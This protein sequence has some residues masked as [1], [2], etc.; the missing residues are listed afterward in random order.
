VTERRRRGLRSSAAAL[1][2]NERQGLIREELAFIGTCDVCGQVR[3]KGVPAAELADRP[4]RGVGWTPTNVMINAFGIIGQTPFGALGDVM[5]V[6]DHSAEI[7]VDYEDGGPIEHLVLADIREADGSPWSCC[8]REFLRRALARLEKLGGLQLLAGFE[9][10]FVYTGVEAQGGNRYWIDAFRRQG[11]FGEAYVA[12][13]RQAGLE[14]E[15]FL[16]EFGVRQYEVTCAPALSL[17]AADQAIFI[18]EL[19]R[20]TAHRFGHRATFSPILDPDGV[21]NGVHIHVSLRDREGRPV[22]FDPERPYRLSAVAEQFSAG[23]LHHMPALCAVTAP[24][25][26]SYIRMTPNRW[27]PT[28][29]NV[30]VQDRAASLRICPTFAG[31]GSDPARQ[32]NVEYRPADA[33]ASPYLALGAVVQAGCEGIEKSMRLPAP[34]EAERSAKPLPRSLEQALELLEATAVAKG[35]FGETLLDAYLKHKRSEIA[36]VERLSPA[37]QCERYAQLY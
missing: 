3:G 2:V 21:G 20:A 36:V 11:S 10:E 31:L 7:R 6:P 15:C 33:A 16:A 35:W 24:S 9:Q 4:H 29:A 28:I 27:A 18:R 8:P 37:E 12:A 23:I 34:E 1:L 5:M 26:I 22:T 19:A 32:F 14:P 25:T 17:A 30:G 13:L